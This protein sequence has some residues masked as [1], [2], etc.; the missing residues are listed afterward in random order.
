[1]MK[2]P[3]PK[4]PQPMSPLAM[5]PSPP[6]FHCGSPNDRSI[7]DIYNFD[8]ANEDL[9]NEEAE[10]EDAQTANQAVV[11]RRSNLPGLTRNQGDSN[12]LL[13]N[14]TVY[15]VPGSVSDSREGNLDFQHELR[16]TIN[17][18]K[19]E[20]V[21]QLVLSPWYINLFPLHRW[22]SHFLICGPEEWPTVERG[23]G[24]IQPPD[25]AAVL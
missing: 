8:E 9:E 15:V 5:Q 22:W 2:L 19:S 20:F 23:H 16:A 21:E 11:N 14:G 24:L 17:N 6:V 7:D 3:V 13:L 4:T 10:E 18:F 25:G 1:M 12:P